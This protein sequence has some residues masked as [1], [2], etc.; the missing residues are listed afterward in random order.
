MYPFLD[1]AYK[2]SFLSQPSPFIYQQ[3]AYQ[4]LCLSGAE[5]SSAEERLLYIPPYFPACVSSQLESHFRMHVSTAAPLTPLHTLQEPL[6]HQEPSSFS[7]SFH[8]EPPPSTFHFDECHLNKSSAKSCLSV[9]TKTSS[10]SSSACDR[11]KNSVPA[12]VSMLLPVS[13]TVNP[14]KTSK[15]S[16]ALSTELSELSRIN[17]G[18]LSLKLHSMRQT[19]SRRHIH[20]SP[21]Q[22]TAEKSLS[23]ART[24][25]D[26]KA[27]QIPLNLSAKEIKGSSNGFKPKLDVLAQLQYGI[28]AGEEQSLKEGVHCPATISAK[29]PEPPQITHFL[30]S[31]L[32]S[33][34]PERLL[35]NESIPG[36]RSVQFGNP[37]SQRSLEPF[38]STKLGQQ[39]EKGLNSKNT[40]T[41][42]EK[43]IFSKVE[44]QDNQPNLPKQ[45][46]P[47]VELRSSSRLIQ[48]ESYVPLE[49]GYSNGYFPYSVTDTVSLH[50]KSV[51]GKGP[52]QDH[53][54]LFGPSSGPTRISAKEGLPHI[55]DSQGTLSPF[56]AKT[57]F[58]ELS[59]NF[60]SKTRDVDQ[61]INKERLEKPS[62]AKKPDP[63]QGVTG[64][65]HTS[66]QTLKSFRKRFI[67]VKENTSCVDVPFKEGEDDFSPKKQKVFLASQTTGDQGTK[68]STSQPQSLY[69]KCSSSSPPPPNKAISMEDSLSSSQDLP[70]QQTMHCARTSPEQFFKK[71]PRRV[72]VASNSLERGQHGPDGLDENDEE[73]HVNQNLS[74]NICASKESSC[75]CDST[76]RFLESPAIECSTHSDFSVST[77]KT[78][79]CGDACLQVLARGGNTKS[80]L[81][82]SVD[83]REPKTP[84]D[85]RSVEVS[86]CLAKD[87]MRENLSRVAIFS[88][89]EKSTRD[90]KDLPL[91][92]GK[93]WGTSTV[94]EHFCRETKEPCASQSSC[95]SQE[96]H[97]LKKNQE[98][99]MAAAGEADLAD[100]QRGDAGE[101][102]GGGLERCQQSGG[103]IGGS[104]PAVHIETP[105]GLRGLEPNLVANREHMFS[106]KPFHQSTFSGCWRKRR[107]TEDNGIKN[108]YKNDVNLEDKPKRCIE[109]NGPCFKRPRLPAEVQTAPSLGLPPSPRQVGSLGLCQPSHFASSRLQEG[110]QKQREKTSVS[111]RLPFSSDDHLDKPTG[112]HPCKTKNTNE[113]AEEGEDEEAMNL[114]VSPDTCSPPPQPNLAIRP[115]STELH[116]LIVNKHGG[117]TLLQR[118]AR[119]GDEEAVLCCLELN[120]CNVNHRNKAGYC[121]L[122][123]ACSRGWLDIVR[124]LVEHGADVNCSARDG[125]RPLHDA[126]END[127]LEV[128]RFLL[129]CGADPNLT[130]N[131]GQRPRNMTNSVSMETFLEEPCSEGG[132]YDIL[133]DPPGPEDEEED[134][135]EETKRRV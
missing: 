73:D 76:I 59:N 72:L 75:I 80:L 10:G 61:C 88:D 15:N 126:V 64:S 65:K 28:L 95:T 102:E 130:S 128:V 135:E 90:I 118:A 34:K 104:P 108:P 12:S 106:L 89:G 83:Q 55:V 19:S 6:V 17:T 30:P 127:H 13:T 60:P 26:K 51:T 50:H 53:P 5:S 32:R 44:G 56:P 77:N 131:S 68:T 35:Q 78:P 47:H 9:S 54:I 94:T 99:E 57:D 63:E 110:H 42:C 100:G 132:V 109:L 36:S 103:G 45:Q 134:E 4:S 31:T 46:Q 124:H 112:K 93:N 38:P 7:T 70:D 24:S 1:M 85:G 2:A 107:R 84:D 114:R 43:Q 96:Q 22:R 87:H 125:T 18:S 116:H 111:S 92:E 27:H 117:E 113:A 23:R 105:T 11:V 67:E 14:R 25:V 8:Q 86:G 79:T 122:R 123:E 33:D 58:N 62:R 29:S 16:T 41:L 101:G 48:T 21:K 121:A 69:H 71:R 20:S 120:L 91:G 66:S 133:A 81:C 52:D 37:P 39:T 129:A 49:L 40:H 98:D 119:L 74:K 82:V 115:T 3:L 97:K